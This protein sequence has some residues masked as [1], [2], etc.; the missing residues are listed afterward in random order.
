MSG[1]DF[2]SMPLSG[3]GFNI[4]TN[5]KNTADVF[6]T[7]LPGVIQDEPFYQ[8]NDTAKA[9]NKKRTGKACDYCRK[10]KIRC[11]NFD[12]NIGKCANC[13][14]FN[15]S[16]TFYFHINLQK[17]RRQKFMNE[18]KEQFK[19]LMNEEAAS[20]TAVNNTNTVTDD[21]ALTAAFP[22]LLDTEFEK[23]G[24]K[25]I[26]I[27][28]ICKN[29][30]YFIE[31]IKEHNDLQHFDYEFLP[32]AAQKHYQTNLFSIPKIRWIHKKIS[33][34]LPLEEFMNPIQ[35]MFNTTFNWYLVQLKKSINLSALLRSDNRNFN[36]LYDL[37]SRQQCKRLLEN[38][39]TS[40]L[41]AIPSL[42]SLDE[43]L[44]ISEKYHSNERLSFSDLFL[45]NVCL[46]KGASSSLI[47][48]TKDTYYLR[49]DKF[50][51]NS[52]DL[53]TIE[54][55]L[56]INVHVYY[57]RL[58]TTN[59]SN[60]K[61][62]KALLI[63]TKYLTLNVSYELAYPVLRRA[64]SVAIDLGLNKISSYA[65]L[66]PE[67]SLKR[68]NLWIHC[69]SSD[70]LFASILCNAPLINGT[71]TNILDDENYIAI[72][73][74]L[75]NSNPIPHNKISGINTMKEAFAYIV[76][77]TRF[78]PVFTAY[79]N[80][81]LINIEDQILTVC[82][83]LKSTQSIAF[84]ELLDT[85][86]KLNEDLMNW[87]GSLNPCMKLESFKEYYK[88]LSFKTFNTETPE[89][90]F[91]IV[92]SRIL[93]IHFRFFY[94]VIMLS[95]FIVAFVNDNRKAGTVTRKDL[96]GLSQKFV[97]QYK[98]Y[99]IKMIKI[100]N[101]L[102]YQP[103]LYNELMYFFNTGVY[104]LTFYLFNQIDDME[105]NLE[106]AYFIEMLVTTHTHIAGENQENFF[107]N[108]MKWNVDMFIFTFLLKKIIQ[109]FNERNSF[110]KIYNFD[111]SVYDQMISTLLKK[112]FEI[113][114]ETVDIFIS[115]LNENEIVS[116]LKNETMDIY[117]DISKPFLRLLKT[118]QAA[119]SILPVLEN[120]N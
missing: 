35:L 118:D 41:Y 26:V 77:N 82:Y 103:F 30:D 19:D 45:L 24:R 110:A 6:Q 21:E 37:P 72:I 94:S 63:F 31:D 91:E 108:N 52:D 25:L 114:Q 62:L 58:L 43:I 39:H 81:K 95:H 34:N 56:S 68:R 86:L 2:A 76:H 100:F 4:D 57:N 66:T 88:L 117:D 73:K 79:Y 67:R 12:S 53:K 18:T 60:L 8:Q 15:M 115:S 16:C 22:K 92:C 78:M 89:L 119:C 14:K 36:A 113:K 84:D 51:P 85:A 61:I 74:Q 1:N 59:A 109:Y 120:R 42:V 96:V 33:S 29:L 55:N 47:I 71:D 49:K 107:G 46:M 27:D 3:N 99:S 90:Q 13:I 83:Q 54:N 28:E 40:V 32:L 38:F 105:N 44:N 116:S 111:P 20:N 48:N 65:H 50:L 112:C 64:V 7:S 11:D 9:T 80:S 93:K 97:K 23:V 75:D 101:S 10:R 70:K 102:K 17:K 98:D 87:Q 69:L 5:M 106:N 104:S